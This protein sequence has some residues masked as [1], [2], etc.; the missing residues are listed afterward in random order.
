MNR[1]GAPG[2]PCR[3]PRPVQRD[4]D[5]LATPTRDSRPFD[6]GVL[7]GLPAPVIRW[8]RQAIA[9]GTPLQ[10]SVRLTMHGEIRVGRWR[11]FSAEQVLAPPRGFVRAATAGRWPP[12]I[13][14]FDRYSQAT[15]EMRWRLGGAIPVMSAAGDDI[16]RSAAGRLASELILVP[17]AALDPAVS[18]HAV[19]EHRATADVRIGDVVLHVTIEVDDRGAVRSLWLP[20]WGNPDGGAFAE[21]PFGGELGGEAT[22][23]GYTIPTTMRVGWGYGTDAWPN[24]IFFRAAI[25]VA[26][27]G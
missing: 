7:D 24:G 22:Y 2:A 6:P 21:H 20:R 9:P 27:Y 17:A 1:A 3:L 18:W 10:R 23:E 8:V 4:W 5:D 14:G 19:D 11:P 16:T 13:R 12:R 26:R 25:D 15:G